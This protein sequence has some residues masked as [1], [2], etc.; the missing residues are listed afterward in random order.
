MGRKMKEI[1]TEKE[2]FEAFRA[3]D[4]DGN[5]F[6]SATERRCPDQIHSASLQRVLELGERRR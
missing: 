3:F 4:R 1:Y 6:I 5:G 2:L